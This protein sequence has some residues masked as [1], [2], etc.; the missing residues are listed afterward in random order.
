MASFGSRPG[1]LSILIKSAP[2]SAR[3][4]VQVGPARTRVRSSTRIGARAVDGVGQ[5]MRFSL[6]VDRMLGKPIFA[7]A[8][9]P[10]AAAVPAEGPPSGFAL[11]PPRLGHCCMRVTA[12]FKNPL[13]PFLVPVYVASHTKLDHWM[14]RTAKFRVL[15]VFSVKLPDLEQIEANHA[16]HRHHPCRARLRGGRV[17]GARGRLRDRSADPPADRV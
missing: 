9:L 10:L 14:D 16:S 5:G 8:A 12:I 13:K 11:L 4:R 6:R 17:R 15:K 2:K 7:A 1:G 3:M